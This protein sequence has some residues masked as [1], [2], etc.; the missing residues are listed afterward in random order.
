[1]FKLERISNSPVLEPRRENPWERGRYSTLPLSIRMDTSI[2]CTGRV[3]AT[4]RR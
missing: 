2:C 4:S 3:T 1:M